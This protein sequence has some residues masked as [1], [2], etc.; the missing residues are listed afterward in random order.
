MLVTCPYSGCLWRGNYEQY[1]PGH[2]TKCASAPVSCP[3]C[4]QSI[5]GKKMQSHKR[6]C[7]NRP[8]SCKHCSAQVPASGMEVSC[9]A[10]LLCPWFI[11]GQPQI[12]NNYRTI[13]YGHASA[14]RD[15]SNVMGV[16]LELSPTTPIRNGESYIEES[17]CITT[18]NVCAGT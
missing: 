5:L 11:S 9:S 14:V 6:V 13:K 4:G 8:L 18:Y 16:P 12:A 15:N 10:V 7:P 1:Y 17:L 3:H 2:L